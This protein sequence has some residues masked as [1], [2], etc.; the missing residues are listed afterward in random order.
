MGLGC[1]KDY[2]APVTAHVVAVEYSYEEFD[3]QREADESL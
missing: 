1:P 3:C 2:V